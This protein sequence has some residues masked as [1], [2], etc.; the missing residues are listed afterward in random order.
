MVALCC[1]YVI[2]NPGWKRENKLYWNPETAIESIRHS[3]Y[4]KLNKEFLQQGRLPGNYIPSDEGMLLHFAY[5]RRKKQYPH[6]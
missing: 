3:Q 6:D 5:D 4:E 2:R 1:L